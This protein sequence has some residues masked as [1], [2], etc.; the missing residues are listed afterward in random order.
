LFSAIRGSTTLGAI[1]KQQL[2]A[3]LSPHTTLNLFSTMAMDNSRRFMSA[4][5]QF[6]TR[7]PHQQITMAG[8]VLY[9]SVLEVLIFRRFLD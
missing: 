4:R 5:E 2:T 9:P 7:S 3:L 8:G 1:I 6:I